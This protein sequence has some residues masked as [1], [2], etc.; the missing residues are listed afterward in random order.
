MKQRYIAQLLS[1][2]DM[3]FLQEHWL[4]ESQCIKLDEPG[5]SVSCHAVSGFSNTEVLAGRPYGGYALIWRKDV[6]Q[7]VRRIHVDGNRIIAFL[8]EVSAIELLIITSAR[9]CLML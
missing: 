7:N 2:C 5:D 4:A 1:R 9:Q 6:L 8:C 3:L